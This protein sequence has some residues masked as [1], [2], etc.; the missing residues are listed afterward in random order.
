MFLN[1]GGRQIYVMGEVAKPG[2][3]RLGADYMN[4]FAAISS[5][6]GTLQ[7]RKTKAYSSSTGY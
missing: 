4:V 2:I 3:Y 1:M 6:N 7:K 5:A